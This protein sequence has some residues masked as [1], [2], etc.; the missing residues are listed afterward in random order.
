[1]T[2]GLWR[3]SPAPPAAPEQLLGVDEGLGA[4]SSEASEPQQGA[5]SSRWLPPMGAVTPI[6]QPEHSGDVFC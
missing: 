2:S 3:K 4:L 1:M 5:D 6:S